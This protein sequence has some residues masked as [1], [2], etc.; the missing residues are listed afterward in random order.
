MAEEREARRLLTE[1]TLRNLG[2]ARR[3]ARR[4]EVLLREVERR[5]RVAAVQ[6]RVALRKL[7]QESRGLL[8]DLARA[9]S[10]YDIASALERRREAMTLYNSL[11]AEALSW[12]SGEGAAI[13]LAGRAARPLPFTLQELAPELL[14][15]LRSYAAL[16]ARSP[17][18]RS[19]LDERLAEA[20]RSLALLLVAT[21]PRTPPDVEL[22][23]DAVLS[24]PEVVSATYAP[25]ILVSRE[26]RERRRG[27]FTRFY[28]PRW[29]E[30][31][32]GLLTCLEAL[33]DASEGLTRAL[34]KLDGCESF[35]RAHL[36]AAAELA[37]SD[38]LYAPIAG[39]F[40]GLLSDLGRGMLRKLREK[41]FAVEGGGVQQGSQ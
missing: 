2:R 11:A 13:A 28:A 34:D 10:I 17:S 41:H 32:E 3:L 7:V 18:F 24:I 16:R 5:S 30:V 22:L 39:E 4:V 1:F 21:S 6:A 37:R 38:P 15:L 35:L 33:V 36:S 20:E 26:R 19:E 27:T 23:V 29:E 8:R 40:E 25:L 9:R 12:L 31:R 14:S